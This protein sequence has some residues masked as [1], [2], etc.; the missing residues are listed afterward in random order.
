MKLPSPSHTVSAPGHPSSQ[1]TREFQAENMRDHSSSCLAGLIPWRWSQQRIST[2]PWADQAEPLSSHSAQPWICAP[3][4]E[5]TLLALLLFPLALGLWPPLW[6]LALLWLLHGSSPS[7]QCLSPPFPL[8]IL[9][10][11]T[12]P[13]LHSTPFV[14][15]P[16]YFFLLRSISSLY[17]LP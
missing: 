2:C 4:Q 1:V 15:L 10:H 7:P 13:S 17:P 9:S 14:Y 8:F 6:T 12:G 16:P 11:G 3:F 5:L